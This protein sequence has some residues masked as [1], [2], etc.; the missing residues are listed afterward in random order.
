MDAPYTLKRFIAPRR[1]ADYYQWDKSTGYTPAI[2]LNNGRLIF[3]THSDLVG[4]LRAQYKAAISLVP[5]DFKSLEK[6]LSKP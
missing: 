5:A 6:E 1:P 4:N 2:R 3:P